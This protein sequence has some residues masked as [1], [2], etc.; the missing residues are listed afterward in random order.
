MNKW[1]LWGIVFY[2][3]IHNPKREYVVAYKGMSKGQIR[4]MMAD[5]KFSYDFIDQATYEKFLKEHQASGMP[6]Q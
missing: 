2:V 5:E 3:Q 1:I 4:Q 6:T